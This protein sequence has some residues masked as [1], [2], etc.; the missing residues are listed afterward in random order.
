MNNLI[1]VIQV[2]AGLFSI[3]GL[4]EFVRRFIDMYVICKSGAVCKITLHTLFL[5]NFFSGNNYSAG[6][7]KEIQTYIGFPSV[8]VR[9]DKI[10]LFD[11]EAA[12][13]S[14]ALL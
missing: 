6:A 7:V 1:T 11:G 9:A 2:I 8:P 13:H 14:L 3:Y 10:Q 4:C 12:I 5:K